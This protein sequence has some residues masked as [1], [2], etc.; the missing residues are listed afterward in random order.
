[1]SMG[2]LLLVHIRVGHGAQST[3]SRSKDKKVIGL[4]EENSRAKGRY[5]NACR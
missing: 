3:G 1:M 2:E 5:E 4:D